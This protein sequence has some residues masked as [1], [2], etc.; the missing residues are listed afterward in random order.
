MGAILSE[1][2]LGA[3]IIISNLSPII[4][5][6]LSDVGSAVMFR[7]NWKIHLENVSTGKIVRESSKKLI[8]RLD[9]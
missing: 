7:T 3:I 4:V 5:S 6:S 2:I 9:R 1:Y 8:F